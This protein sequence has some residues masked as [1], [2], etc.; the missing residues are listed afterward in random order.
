MLALATGSPSF[1]KLRKRLLR[2]SLFCGFCNGSKEMGGEPKV[3]QWIL[4]K[5]PASD[6][7]SDS[8][9]GLEESMWLYRSA[10]TAPPAEWPVIRREHRDREGSS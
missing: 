2:N 4:L 10:A 3:T 8:V 5:K 1:M 6:L 7:R 9:S